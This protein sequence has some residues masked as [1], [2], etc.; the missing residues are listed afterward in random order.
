MA[1]KA[2]GR[3]PRQ[4]SAASRS[5][6]Q[7]I[8]DPMPGQKEWSVDNL[9]DI[10][11][12]FRPTA[13]QVRSQSNLP[14]KPSPWGSGPDLRIF[15]ILP[16]R[17]STNVEEF[18]VEAW[19]RMD[20]RIQLHDITDRMH[21]EFRIANNALQQRG[22]RF[23]QA[24]DILSWGSGNKQTKVVAD[25]LEKEMQ[26]RGIDPTLN[27]TR[28]LT[29]GLINL[30]LGEAGGRVPVP[31]AYGHRFRAF[32]K[33]QQ[34]LIQQLETMKQSI[35]L[36]HTFATQQDM[37]TQQF[38]MVQPLV[39]PGDMQHIVPGSACPTYPLSQL[40]TQFL[41]STAE[42]SHHEHHGMIFENS[43]AYENEQGNDGDTSVGIGSYAAGNVLDNDTSHNRFSQQLIEQE[44]IT[45]QNSDGMRVY[46][47]Q[48]MQNDAQ[49]ESDDS[50]MTDIYDDNSERCGEEQESASDWEERDGD[51]SKVNIPDASD[52]APILPLEDD[53]YPRIPYYGGP[54]EVETEPT[55]PTKVRASRVPIERMMEQYID[56]PYF[57]K[58][59][60]FE[61]MRTIQAV[62]PPIHPNDTL[63][64]EMVAD[65]WELFPTIPG[66]LHDSLDFSD[67]Q[68][69]P[70]EYEKMERAMKYHREYDIDIDYCEQLRASYGHNFT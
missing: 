10:L 42:I 43:Q 64:G 1:A 23:R 49:S 8:T 36:P 34:K 28:G 3:P 15:D 20:R 59:E 54:L 55:T 45:L 16:D 60:M 70:T 12:I 5:N 19:M 30:A 40:V 39:S 58:L 24:F 31:E 38:F 14:I 11:Y 52:G 26:A 51:G 4:H 61:A 2:K 53:I 66:P 50:E 29:P 22:V 57:W 17:I 13:P 62:M 67:G 35:M 47:S 68:Q 7:N 56:I 63:P 32:A 6:L 18:R 48:H 21:P 27:S 33:E 25:Q 65:E 44:D 9:P 69:E 41:A 46:V 37:V